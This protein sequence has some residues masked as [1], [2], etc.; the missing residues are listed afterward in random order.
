MIGGPG[1]VDELES[2]RAVDLEMLLR[3]DGE[4]ILGRAPADPLRVD[5]AARDGGVVGGDERFVGALFSR[6]AR[7][8]EALGREGRAPEARRGRCDRA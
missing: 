7:G 5:C 1:V 4:E 6:P 3:L 2:E 8:G